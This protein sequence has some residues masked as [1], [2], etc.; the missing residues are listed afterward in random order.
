MSVERVPDLGRALQPPNPKTE[1]TPHARPSVVFLRGAPVPPHIVDHVIEA[2]ITYTY[3]CHDLPQYY[4]GTVWTITNNEIK[5]YEG[6]EKKSIFLKDPR[7]LYIKLMFWGGRAQLWIE[8]RWEFLLDLTIKS[9][10]CDTC[11][12]CQI[13]DRLFKG[14]IFARI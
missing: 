5:I 6:G 2:H 10:L 7:I 13:M 11:Y 1:S 14:L 4:S 3:P 9:L 8:K 12:T